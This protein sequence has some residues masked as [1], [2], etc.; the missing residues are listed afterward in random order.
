MKSIADIDK[1]LMEWHPTKN[2][3]HILKEFLQI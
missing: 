2:G 1:L 3:D